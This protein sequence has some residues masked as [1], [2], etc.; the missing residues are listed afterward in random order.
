MSRKGRF[1]GSEENR[2]RKITL[3][4]LVAGLF[5][6]LAAL[7]ASAGPGNGNSGNSNGRPGSS[8]QVYVTSQGLYYDSIVKTELPQHQGLDSVAYH[9]AMPH[10]APRELENPA[11]PC[12]SGC[13]RDGPRAGVSCVLRVC[14]LIRVLGSG[15]CELVP[16][17]LEQV[18]DGA[19]ETP[20][21]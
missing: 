14:V 6:V 16:V 12:G 2:M 20:F 19:D 21:A 1:I 5:L 4:A 11:I 18:V 15:G 8:V 9:L 17:D 7:P 13:R 3:V 10:I